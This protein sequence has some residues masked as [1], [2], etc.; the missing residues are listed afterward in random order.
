[1]IP[2]FRGKR[3]DTGEWVYGYLTFWNPYH[4]YIADEGVWWYERTLIG[5]KAIP[6]TRG[7]L[8]RVDPS[9]TGQFIGLKDRNNKEIYEGDIVEDIESDARNN[10][11][12]ITLDPD[13]WGEVFITG[14]EDAFCYRDFLELIARGRIEVIGNIHDNPDLIAERQK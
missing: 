12:I 14:N 3:V 9:T 13:E 5:D 2:K 6:Y 4:A 10:W 7:N 1:M 8:Y 11:G